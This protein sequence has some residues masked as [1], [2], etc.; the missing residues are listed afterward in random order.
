MNTARAAL[1][2]QS[3]PV[4]VDKPD[5]FY[6]LELSDLI[7]PATPNGI[8]CRPPR[9]D[10]Q[11]ELFQWRT[12]Y[13]IEL[14]G[15]SD[16]PE[17]RERAA[18]FLE[19]QIARGQAW[20]AVQDGRLLSLC[21]FNAALPDIVQ[22]GGIYTPPALRRRGYARIVIAASLLTARERGVGRAVL[23][24]SNPNAARCYETLGFSRE[25]DYALV[26]HR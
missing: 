6:G 20:V 3:V 4:A 23:F 21:A 10:E 9:F 11:P 1:G 12:A 16:T 15:A 18:R 5:A 26:I 13:D 25:G 8:E 2:L 17:T 14:L 24:T 19:E 7:V 22:L